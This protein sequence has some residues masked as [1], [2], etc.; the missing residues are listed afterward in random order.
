MGFVRVPEMLTPEII[1]A[2]AGNVYT[3]KSEPSP[4]EEMAAT[5]REYFKAD[6]KCNK[7]EDKKSEPKELLGDEECCCPK[8]VKFIFVLN[9]AAIIN[10]NAACEEENTP[11]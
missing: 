10:V 5:L 8:K 7:K 3:C 9:N 6:K 1:K 2:L 11:A 4:K